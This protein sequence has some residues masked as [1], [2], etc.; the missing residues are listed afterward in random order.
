MKISLGW[1]QA[2]ISGLALICLG[3]LMRAT[4][5]QHADRLRAA[6]N[7]DGSACVSLSERYM[8]E[9]VTVVDGIEGIEYGGW[10]P[11]LNFCPYCNSYALQEYCSKCGHKQ[12]DFFY[13]RVCLKCK[14]RWVSASDPYCNQCGSTLTW[15]KVRRD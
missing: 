3:F 8:G 5:D 13:D 7:T 1:D 10:T 12:S 14:A 15:K 6:I 2:L 9:R 11:I 4:Y